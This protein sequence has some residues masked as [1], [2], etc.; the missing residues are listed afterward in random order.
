MFRPYLHRVGPKCAAGIKTSPSR[1]PS[2][3]PK[4]WRGAP[5]LQQGPVCGAH[6]MQSYAESYPPY[7]GTCTILQEAWLVTN[8]VCGAARAA[9]GSAAGSASPFLAHSRASSSKSATSATA[10]SAQVSLPWREISQLGGGL[11][12]HRHQPFVSATST[13]ERFLLQK[14][15]KAALRCANLQSCGS[16]ARNRPKA[17]EPEVLSLLAA[18]TKIKRLL[19]SR[20]RQRHSSMRASVSPHFL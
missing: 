9:A 8:V 14:A 3:A 1:S 6:A 2:L 17:T 12:P 13:S 18:A 10:S 15:R 20:A 4:S 11:H 16:E 7:L 5:A 19:R